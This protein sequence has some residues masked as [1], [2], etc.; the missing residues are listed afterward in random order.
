MGNQKRQLFVPGPPKL[1]KSVSFRSAF[2]VTRFRLPVS[3]GTNNSCVPLLSNH[4]LELWPAPVEVLGRVPAHHD[5]YEATARLISL[6][7][8]LCCLF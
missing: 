3:G 7:N 5:V 6:V 1:S 4:P 8:F 2:F